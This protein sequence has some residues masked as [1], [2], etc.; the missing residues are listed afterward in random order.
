MAITPEIVR[1]DPTL[2]LALVA[3]KPARQSEQAAPR[4]FRAWR[5]APAWTGSPRIALRRIT[6]PIALLGVALRRIAL[7][8]VTLLRVTLLWIGLR[9]IG[10][11]EA[12]VVAV[13]P[14][15]TERLAIASGLAA[16]IRIGVLARHEIVLCI[17]GVAE[18]I[19]PEILH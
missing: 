5:L 18:V 4:G 15:A 1:I 14:P 17:F 8:R 6:L 19:G 12:L 13:G 7:L 3:G 11:R 16:A 2:A 10:R 9:R